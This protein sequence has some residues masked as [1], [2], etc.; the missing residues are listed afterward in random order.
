MTSGDL[1]MSLKVE[2]PPVRN[3]FVPDPGWVWFDIDLAG[4][5]AQVVAWDAGDEDLKTAFRNKVPIHVKNGSDIWSKELMFSKDDE[6]K[7]EPYYTRVKRGVH[8]LN[9]GGQTS[10][11]ARKCA[12]SMGEANKFETTWFS[13]HPA[14]REWHERKMFEIQTTGMTT[15]K[16]GYN[17]PWFDRPSLDIWRRALAWTPQSTIA[18]VT[19][20]AMIRLYEERDVNPYFRKGF[21]FTMQ[22]HDSLDFIVKLDLIPAV[23]PRIHELLHSIVIPYDDPLIIP[24]G[25]KRGRT[26]WGECAKAS[27]ESLI[28]GEGVSRLAHSVPGLYGGH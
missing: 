15:N 22:V 14:L 6:G 24:W 13:L 10:T 19:E 5:D 16:F 1:S 26:S 12:M 2:W 20:E 21:R 7:S 3:I 17:I 11:L 25:I 28:N 27:W 4:A 23:M 9:Y 8:L 18:H